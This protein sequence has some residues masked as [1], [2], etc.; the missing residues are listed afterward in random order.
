[1]WNGICKPTDRGCPSCHGYTKSRR[2]LPLSSVS[3]PKHKLRE[4]HECTILIH[5]DLDPIQYYGK[6]FGRLV[7]IA[8]EE[9][10]SAIELLLTAP[11]LVVGRGWANI[12]V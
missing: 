12:L 5:S 4:Q 9:V 3:L 7:V 11:A 6:Q 2:L 1:M 10:R 8:L